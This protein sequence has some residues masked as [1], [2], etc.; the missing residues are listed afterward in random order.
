MLDKV[1]TMLSRS[2]RL[3]AVLWDVQYRLGVWDRLDSGTVMGREFAKMTAEFAPSARILDLGCGTSVNLPLE[4]GTYRSYHGVDISPK[5]IKRARRAGRPGATYEVADILTY[6]PP[7][8]YDAILLRE[9]IYYLTPQ[10]IHDLLTRLSA[11]L[12]QDGVVLI[13]VW[14]GERSPDLKAAI[15]SS[16]LTL[17]AERTHDNDVHHP[18]VY[19]LKR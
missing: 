4:P 19:V 1:F 8:T 11:Y 3:N 14:S 15:T 13:Q 7:G 5:A 17:V 10:Q 12:S 6:Q 2:P 18:T 16:L 9:V